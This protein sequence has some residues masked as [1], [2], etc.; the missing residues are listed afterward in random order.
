MTVVVIV[1]SIA[2][3]VL[4]LLCI[5]QK[6][7]MR[8][9]EKQLAEIKDEDTNILIHSGN[10]TADA[11]INRIN[12]LLKELREM[13]AVYTQKSHALEQMMTNISHDLRTPLTSAMG[14]INMI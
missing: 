13:R 2:A 5:L 6:R 14:Y 7:E 8:H 1:L 10:G 3:A 11:L 12:T 9:I 4:L